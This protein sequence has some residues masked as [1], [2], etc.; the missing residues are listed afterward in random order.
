[1][2]SLEVEVPRESIDAGAAPPE[3]KDTPPTREVRHEYTHS[4]PPPF[5][6]GD[7]DRPGPALAI[8]CGLTVRL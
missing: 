6:G 8:H 3:Q 2:S 4:L 7:L 5:R 1:M